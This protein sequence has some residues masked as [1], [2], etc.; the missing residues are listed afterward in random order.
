MPAAG[1]ALVVK[2]AARIPDDGSLRVVPVE[3]LAVCDR[4]CTIAFAA[5]DKWTYLIGDIDPEHDS[6]DIILAAKR[7]SGSPAPVLALADRPSFFRKGVIG[8]V[9]SV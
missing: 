3:C 6:D 9:P 8:R 5:P 4:P 7:L 2:L 1:E